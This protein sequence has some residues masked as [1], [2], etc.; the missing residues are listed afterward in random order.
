MAWRRGG[1][2]GTCKPGARDAGQDFSAATPRTK[3]GWRAEILQ[4]DAKKLKR[5]DVDGLWRRLTD[6]ICGG[7]RERKQHELKEARVEG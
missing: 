5:L 7:G 6:E 2:R 4:Q 1:E 3:R